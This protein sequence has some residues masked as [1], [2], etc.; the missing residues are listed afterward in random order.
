[1]PC[2]VTVKQP[3]ARIVRLEG[4]GNVATSRHKHNVPSRRVDEVERRVAGDRV[5]SGILLGKNDNVHAMPVEWVCNCQET[6]HQQKVA[7]ALLECA[8]NLPLSLSTSGG[9]ERELLLED[10][11][12]IKT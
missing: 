7:S 4:D 10:S 5:K 11:I 1:M 6:R 2:N 8:P 12:I 9:R 3:H